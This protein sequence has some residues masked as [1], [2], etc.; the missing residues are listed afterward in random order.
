ME[1]IPYL[2]ITEN[3]RTHQN[4]SRQPERFSEATV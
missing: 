4:P 1:V 3:E 2:E